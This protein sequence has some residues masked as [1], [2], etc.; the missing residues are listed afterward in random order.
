MFLHPNRPKDDV[1]TLHSSLPGIR[2][3]HPIEAYDTGSDSCRLFMF[4]LL[5]SFL[6]G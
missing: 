6:V 5:G 3:T 1:A 4:R 2:L